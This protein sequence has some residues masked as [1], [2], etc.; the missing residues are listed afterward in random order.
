[1]QN[2]S[3]TEAS[4][5]VLCQDNKT[6]ARSV[7]MNDVAE[8][9]EE[10]CVAPVG[11]PN[12]VEFHFVLPEDCCRLSKCLSGLSGLAFVAQSLQDKFRDKHAEWS[13]E[14]F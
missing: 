14:S 1:M 12:D 11:F 8:P 6:E 2:K 13:C 3:G 5:L 4:F 10:P 7:G 9:N